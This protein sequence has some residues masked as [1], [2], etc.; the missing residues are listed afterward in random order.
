MGGFC[1]QPEQEKRADPDQRAAARLHPTANSQVLASSLFQGVCALV[2]SVV[3][4]S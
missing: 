1:S 4:D 3:Y 2:A